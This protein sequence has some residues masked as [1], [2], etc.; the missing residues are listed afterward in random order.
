MCVCS[1]KGPFYAT[2]SEPQNIEELTNEKGFFFFFFLV[3]KSV[4]PKQID[5][6]VCHFPSSQAEGGIL[7][8][9]TYKAVLAPVK[10]GNSL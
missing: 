2:T 9:H 8:W 10:D 6:V 4:N 5:G 3:T 7:S 1:A